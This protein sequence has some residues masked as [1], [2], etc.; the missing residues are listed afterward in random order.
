MARATGTA[1]LRLL[2]TASWTRY[3]R[4]N[5]TA[6][7]SS[8][9]H[10]GGPRYLSSPALLF[11]I[12]SFS[13]YSVDPVA[14]V[15]PR[16]GGRARPAPM[17]SSSAA[18][19][20]A[21]RGWSSPLPAASSS[22]GERRPAPGDELLGVS[23]STHGKLPLGEIRAGRRRERRRRRQAPRLHPQAPSERIFSFSILFHT[24]SKL[25]RSFFLKRFFWILFRP[26]FSAKSFPQNIC[27]SFSTNISAKK[28]STKFL[29]NILLQKNLSGILCR[30]LLLQFL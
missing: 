14:M 17:G 16:R 7:R 15:E 6:Q 9:K 21:P 19:R 5:H 18:R 8:A 3:S 4:T 1:M 28:T 10:M 26:K 11:P 20:W 12:F 29:K 30:L 24:S 23:S 22:L 27:L 13:F 25:I 2:S